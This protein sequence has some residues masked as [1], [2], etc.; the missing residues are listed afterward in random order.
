MGIDVGT[1]Q[2][3]AAVFDENWSMKGYAASPNEILRSKDGFAEQ[4]AE[5][6]FQTVLSVV[7]EAVGRSGVRN[8]EAVGL[9]V[10]GDA[11]IPVDKNRRALA[12]AQLGMDYRAGE[13]TD[14]LS[15]RFGAE[16]MFK[17]TGMPPH[18]MNTLCKI[19]WFKK[20]CPAL[21]ERVWKYMTYADF[22]LSKLGAEEPVIDRSMAS[23]TMALSLETGQWD[24]D[25]F[26]YGALPRERFCAPAEPGTTVG[27]LS[28]RICEETGITGRALLT[29]GGHDQTCAALGAGL[30]EEGIALDSHG[31]AEVLSSVLQK[32]NLSRRFFENGFPCYRHVIPKQYFTFALNHTGGLPFQWV[33]DQFASQEAAEA[34]AS[35]RDT[36]DVILEKMPVQPTN[37]IAI[38]FPSGGAKGSVHGLTFSTTRHEFAKAILEATAMELRKNLLLLCAAGVK[39]QEL[40]CVG[41]GAKSGIGLQLKADILGLPV[42]TMKIR[43]AACLGA[44][45]LAGVGVG[46]FETAAQAAR[47]A[48][49]AKVFYPEQ[50]RAAQYAEK[51]AEYIEISK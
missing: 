11:F 1:T 19:L 31:T 21:D 23:R 10:Q 28:K 3:K 45:E 16:T 6:V 49:T 14:E 20:H 36:Y 46:A 40:R 4:D 33:H 39:I 41:G 13:E 47:L 22:L 15:G 43:E 30:F 12:L 27:T 5:R 32:S 34:K 2:T 50:Q 29:A 18:P 35:G 44:A 7:R 38:P 25:L 37:L 48:E 8:L 24:D 17:K 51:Y 9:S 42:A 26:Q